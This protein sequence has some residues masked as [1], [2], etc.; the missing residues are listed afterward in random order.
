VLLNKDINRY[1]FVHEVS[2]LAKKMEED[3]RNP[4]IEQ[5]SSAYKEVNKTKKKRNYILEA[6]EI[7]KDTRVDDN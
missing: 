3:D 1:K 7:L 4:I 5:K 6:F 2:E